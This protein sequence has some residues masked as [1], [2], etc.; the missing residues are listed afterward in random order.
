MAGRPLW[1]TTYRSQIS[2][3]TAT[4]NAVQIRAVTNRSTAARRP[5]TNRD[6]DGIA[7][8]NT[9]VAANSQVTGA[10]P[11]SSAGSPATARAIAPARTGAH[12]GR[13][14]CEMF[15]VPDVIWRSALIRTVRAGP[16]NGS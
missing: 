3:E 13:R 6:H 14:G 1:I 2:G 7:T 5:S 9:T 8:I 10:Q 4:A 16:G 11:A 12:R 15:I